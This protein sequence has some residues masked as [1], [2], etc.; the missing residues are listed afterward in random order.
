[1]SIVRGPA[2]V[3]ISV[4]ERGMP[5]DLAAPMLENL[6]HRGR[7]IE[8]HV[9]QWELAKRKADLPRSSPNLQQGIAGTELGEQDDFLRN[10]VTYARGQSS[11]LVKRPGLFV[12]AACRVCHKKGAARPL[13]QSYLCAL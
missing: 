8:P 11:A 13:D 12:K 5:A 6:E 9:A 7:S 2:V 10:R 4:D 1:G 3:A